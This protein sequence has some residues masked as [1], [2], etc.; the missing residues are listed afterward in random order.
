[1][2]FQKRLFHSTHNRYLGR[3]VA[4]LER[5][6]VSTMIGGGGG[7]EYLMWVLI[8]TIRWW[9]VMSLSSSMMLLL[10]S[11]S[12]SSSMTNLYFGGSYDNVETGS[13]WSRV[14]FGNSLVM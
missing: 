12:S 4:S 2:I 14:T 5:D 3:F 1:M 10:S 13:A 7:D 8:S 9:F 6:V 11:S